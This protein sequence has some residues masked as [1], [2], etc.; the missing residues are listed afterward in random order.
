MNNNTNQND[1]NSW[2]GSD[3]AMAVAGVG[4]AVS[5]VVVAVAAGQRIQ[6]AESFSFQAGEVFELAANGVKAI[7]EVAKSV[8]G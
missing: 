7:G 3:I 4:A 2:S 6:D 8:T 1:N 5:M